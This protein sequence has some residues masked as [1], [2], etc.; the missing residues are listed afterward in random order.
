LN[1]A[2]WVSAN[3]NWQQGA[4]DELPTASDVIQT[5]GLKVSAVWHVPVP[6]PLDSLSGTDLTA[7]RHP[8]ELHCLPGFFVGADLIVCCAGALRGLMEPSSRK[9]IAPE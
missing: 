2:L 6:L 4:H 7:P 3:V 8:G 5:A 9:G 1:F